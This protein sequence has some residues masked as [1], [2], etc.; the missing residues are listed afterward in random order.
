MQ[1]FKVINV[2]ICETSDSSDFTSDASQSEYEYPIKREKS[3]LKLVGKRHTKVKEKF[4]RENN[5][6]F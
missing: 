6:L 4:E 3:P 1:F 2:K 5:V